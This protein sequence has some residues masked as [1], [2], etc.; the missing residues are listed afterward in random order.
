MVATVRV[1]AGTG[2]PGTLGSG[3]QQFTGGALAGSTNPFDVV[4]LAALKANSVNPSA[5]TT[6]GE[7]LR[8]VTADIIGRLPTEAELQA[9]LA[10]TDPAKR[11]KTIDSLL[12]MP[13][14]AMHWSKDI[15]GAWLMVTGANQA[16]FD[17]ELNKQLGLDTPLSTIL[18]SIATG[19]GPMGTAFD[20]QFPMAYMKSDTLDLVFTGMTSKCARCHDH[21]LTTANDNP[22]WIQDQNY[23]LY[24]FFAAN[25]NDA[26]KVDKSGKMFGTPL[27]PA[28]AWDPTVTG[29]PK[30]TD[31]IA[32]R[33]QKW[34]DLMTQSTVFA[35]GTGHRIWAE[36][37]GPMLDPNQFL[38]VNLAGVANPKLLD[39]VAQAFMDQKTSLKGFIR[40]VTNSKLYQLSGS[41]KDTKNDGLYARHVVRRHHS[42]VLDA[43]T[44]SIAGVPYTAM[45]SFFSF[46]F[47][48]PSTRLTITERTDAVNMS[49]AFT[50]MN[51]THG[52]NG[53][54]VMTGNQIDSLA[55][56]VDQGTIKLESAVTTIFHAGL[57]RDPSAAELTAFTNERASAA[58]TQVFL[59]DTAVAVGASIEFVMR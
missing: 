15:V 43:G 45:D 46:N 59:Q 4:A 11:S 48:Y 3:F 50:Q 21:P 20:A 55:K 33:R 52:T 23:S 56:S 1:I 40:L 35:R 17:A 31:P 26:T 24:A 36:L 51:S 2:S 28:W 19:T 6:D 53:R 18:T 30:L 38:Q 10:S 42:E 14:F 37:M 44:S 41:G 7:F 47:G 25:A 12:A 29:L 32:T 39:A 16:A 58:S 34:A 13:E 22:R 49:Q 9:F 5:L 54:M 8:R 57:S 27:D